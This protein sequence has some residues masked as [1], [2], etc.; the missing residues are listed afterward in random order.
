[1]EQ[2]HQHSIPI[3]HPITTVGLVI[4]TLTNLLFCLMSTSTPELQHHHVLTEWN[5]VHQVTLLHPHP[6]ESGVSSPPGTSSQLA[7]PRRSLFWLCQMGALLLTIVVPRWWGRRA[8][9]SAR[10]V[11]SPN[12][13]T[14]SRT[15]WWIRSLSSPECLLASLQRW[16]N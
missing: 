8:P 6:T 4:L 14:S 11:I 7:W 9:G 3:P 1:M 12:R 15:N 10:N 5:P 2:T 16:Q 13:L